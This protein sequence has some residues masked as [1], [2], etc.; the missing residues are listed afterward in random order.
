MAFLVV[1][2]LEGEKT[3]TLFP[4]Q[5]ASA[6]DFLVPG[7][8]LKVGVKGDM[9]WSR[10]KKC[11]IVQSITASKRINKMLWQEIEEKHKKDDLKGQGFL[12]S[13]FFKFFLFKG[14]K[15]LIK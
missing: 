5:Y 3:L 6:K 14:C 15:A 8:I 2:T 4:R 11:F 12:S 9:N 13:V 10:N 7:M 1:D